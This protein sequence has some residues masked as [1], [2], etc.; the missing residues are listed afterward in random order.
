MTDGITPRQALSEDLLAIPD[1]LRRTETA[2]AADAT[3]T[4]SG[5]FAPLNAYAEHATRP[6]GTAKDDWRA[7]VP[8]PPDAPPADFRH[9]QHGEP[10]HVFTYRDSVGQILFYVRRYTN[11]PKA[12]PLAYCE[13]PDGTRQ[14]RAKWPTSP[15]SL[16]RLEQLAM[17][18]DAPVLVVEGEKT[19]DT[20]QR[21]FPTHVVVTTPGGAKAAHLADFEP[22][23]G[24]TVT[25]WPDHDREG[26]E[27]ARNAKRLAEEAEARC[28]IV[29]VPAEFPEKWD[30]ADT[31][32]P[33]F[34]VETLRAM[35]L[36]APSSN[37]E[38]PQLDTNK[39]A[40]MPT[41]QATGHAIDAEI[42]R[43]A[44]LPALEYEQTR[45]QHA[46]RLE[47]RPG[48]LDKLVKDCQRKLGIGAYETHG[49]GRSLEL[50]TPAPFAEAVDGAQL[51]SELSTTI[52]RY[53]ALPPGAA[54]AMALWAV[55]THTIDE[56]QC[57]PRLMF[58]SPEKR[59]GKSTALLIVSR[60]VPRPLIAANITPS[61]LFRTV[62]AAA[63]TLIVDEGDTFI[64]KSDELGGILNSGHT[65]ALAFVIRNVGDDHEPRKFGTWCALAIASIGNLPDTLE[66]RSVI[67]TMRRRRPD[68]RVE[69]LRIDRTS[70]LDVLA[71]KAARW[72]EDNRVALHA[73]D[74]EM[75]SELNDRA[76]DNWR[77]LIAIADVA[78]GDWPQRAR[79][80]AVLLSGAGNDD[81]DSARIKLLADIEH[82]FTEIGLEWI[83]S[84]ELLGR[85]V[86]LEDHPWADY[87]NG[88]S[89][90]PNGLA[91]LLRAY[92]IRPKV[93]RDGAAT[94]RGYHR[95][96]FED[97]F[98]RY[99]AGAPETPKHPAGI[100][101][102]VPATAEA[103]GHPVAPQ[104]ADNPLG[105]NACF[106][107]AAQD[108]KNAQ[109]AP[110]TRW[111]ARI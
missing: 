25:L 28:A 79:K 67:V 63:P 94:L 17:R 53:L 103:G 6:I 14:W 77:P 29:Q 111:R 22:L 49:Q 44:A 65:R 70:H 5:M 98:S 106:G 39:A 61:A 31:P 3:K 107:V 76:A 30:L 64:A 24:R 12:L 54:D 86:A 93:R 47:V 80:A 19:A 15:R 83:S 9:W 20:A 102:L 48:V 92:G 46:E 71:S 99:L 60:L 105:P 42:R 16:Y 78:G 4:A 68:E 82:V 38:R 11:G 18:P 56:F 23:K 75:P 101:A 110:A 27:Y 58:K 43:L 41:L 72:A 66:D 85:L 35:A 51:F 91:G 36:G 109:D 100:K 1:F 69:R 90:N 62:E 21:L 2:S 57:S 73:A 89:L 33:G 59:C 37:A 45:K 84:S 26:E 95:Q 40:H 96:D 8:V 74:P 55:F 88:K 104:E 87:R 32:P 81:T 50:P 7:I 10:S 108:R 97:A 34:S 13:A 52:S